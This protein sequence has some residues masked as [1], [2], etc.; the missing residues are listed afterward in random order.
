MPAY[1]FK[2]LSQHHTDEANQSRLVT[3]FKWAV[4]SYHGRLKQWKFFYNVK[5]N[6]HISH[7]KNFVTI[8]SAA[9]NAFRPPLT[10]DKPQDLAEANLT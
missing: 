5:E 6:H 4:E 2:G 10:T 7:M 8:T 9:M 3:K 1:L